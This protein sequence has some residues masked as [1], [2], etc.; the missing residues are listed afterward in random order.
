M[1]RNQTTSQTIVV[2]AMGVVAGAGAVA[3]YQHAGMPGP[4]AATAGLSAY[5][6][7]L[8]VHAFLWRR[9][10]G[11]AAEDLRADRLRRSGSSAG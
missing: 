1:T 11:E 9:E 4:V 10:R 2:V 7:L 5:L 3:L 6:M 8:G